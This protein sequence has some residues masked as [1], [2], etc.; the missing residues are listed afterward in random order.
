MKR[1]Y[2]CAGCGVG[3]Y[4]GKPPKTWRLMMP[5][6]QWLCEGCLAELASVAANQAQESADDGAAAL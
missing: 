4:A 3:R 1:T 6:G 5:D 2:K